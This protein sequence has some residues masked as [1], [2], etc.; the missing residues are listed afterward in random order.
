MV[1]Q[2]WRRVARRRMKQSQTDRFI[3][4]IGPSVW[5]RLL[6]LLPHSSSSSR[7]RSRQTHHHHAGDQLN[8]GVWLVSMR[9]PKSIV[10]TIMTAARS[11]FTTTG[12]TATTATLVTR[13]AAPN[14]RPVARTIPMI[15]HRKGM[16]IFQVQTFSRER[17]KR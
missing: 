17:K 13:K 5:N 10:S 8:D 7:N 2:P 9:W 1:E 12:T 14:H 11:T 3:C 4:A 16:Q 6:R 15:I